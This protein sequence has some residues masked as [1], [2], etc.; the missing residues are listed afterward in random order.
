[1][2]QF[3]N[4]ETMNVLVTGHLGY[5]GTVVTPMLGAR[6]HTVKGCDTGF[7]ADRWVQPGPAT[8]AR[9]HALDV[10]QIE[11]EHLQG[12]DAVVHL[13]ALSNDP[14]GQLDPA[15]TDAINHRASVRLARLARRAGVRRFVFASS[16][17][18]Y[19]AADTSRPLD[20]SAPFNPVSAYARSKVDAEAGIAALAGADFAPVFLR[21]ATA[22]GVS[23]NMRFDL[24]ANNLVG[25]AL[26]TG[27]IRLMSDGSPWRPLVHVEDIARASLAALEAPQAAVHNQAFN[28]GQ[29]DQNFQV[30]EIAEGV[31][32]AIPGCVVELALNAGPDP[33]SYRVN[34]AKAR[35]R[36]P[37]FQPQWTLEAGV[38]EM[39]DFFRRRGLTGAEFQGRAYVRLAQLRYLLD[40]GLLSPQLY[41]TERSFVPS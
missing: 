9:G 28:I 22:Y 37:G 33:R 7:F 32:R 19:G 17:S 18:L 26:T 20:E 15:V 2:G 5:I 4:G 38:Q 27:V 41:W 35:K 13:A 31:R 3:G 12:I 8:W 6:G 29:D 39:V 14:L 36:L 11:A 30:R 21:N 1:V 10:R 25:W 34:F 23:P 24:V 16:C 40:T